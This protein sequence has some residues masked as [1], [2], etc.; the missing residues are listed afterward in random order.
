MNTP[1][2]A[3]TTL[4]QQLEW[5]YATKKFDA[6]K[7]IPAETWA[8]LEQAL[9]LSPSSFGLQ[10]WRFVV[11]KTPETRKTLQQHSWN[12]S[13]V[14][15]AS[16]LVVIASKNEVSEGDVGEFLS[17]VAETRSMELAALDAYRSMIL[18]FV[19]HLSSAG[20]IP[21]WTT[22]QSYIALGFL[23][24]SAAMLGID[25]CPLEGINPQKYDEILGL[26][27]QGYSARVACA[28]GYRASDD[29]ASGLKKVRFANNRVIT[30]V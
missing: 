21:D 23:L 4:L 7:H 5:R 26:P 14:V 24:S 3:P 2:V 28:L 19:A 8:A 11:V 30:H 12:Q 13:Q 27:E 10:P 1:T 25:S 22:K 20:K 29:K 16:H 9:V 17:L 18:Q 6:N 15:D